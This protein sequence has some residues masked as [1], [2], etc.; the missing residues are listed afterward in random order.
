MSIFALLTALPR[1]GKAL[2]CAMHEFAPRK[3]FCH[4]LNSPIKDMTVVSVIA[5]DR[6]AAESTSSREKSRKIE[7][8]EVDLDTVGPSISEIAH[9]RVI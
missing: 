7:Q 2:P 4:F 5:R 8:K 3:N 6:I 1:W 9:Y